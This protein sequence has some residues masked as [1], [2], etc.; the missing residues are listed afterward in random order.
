MRWS[1]SK[2]MSNCTRICIN[3]LEV[4]CFQK[5]RQ[6]WQ[7]LIYRQ[8]NINFV[9][10][11]DI[12]IAFNGPTNRL[13]A[14][15]ARHCSCH[16]G[17]AHYEK[18]YSTNINQPRKQDEATQAPSP[19]KDLSTHPSKWVTLLTCLKDHPIA[20]RSP[21]TSECEQTVSVLAMTNQCFEH[22]YLKVLVIL[23][24]C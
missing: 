13:P 22:M 23:N 14:P 10:T 4:F 19:C 1:L 11:I 8:A 7:S 16:G 15:W 18:H 17:S 21:A 9:E 20:Q 24:Y 12:D 2:R 6:I 3:H 5:E